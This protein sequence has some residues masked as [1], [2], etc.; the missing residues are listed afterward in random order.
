LKKK[1]LKKKPKLI[2][3]NR[4]LGKDQGMEKAPKIKLVTDEETGRCRETYLCREVQHHED[5]EANE[6]ATFFIL[7]FC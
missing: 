1:T 3:L 4:I 6:C 5:E 2:V 7:G